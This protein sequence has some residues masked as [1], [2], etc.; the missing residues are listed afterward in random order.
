[1]NAAVSDAFRGSRAIADVVARLA[2]LGN[3]L[4]VHKPECH[5]LTMRRRDLDLLLRYPKA[6][7]QQNV[8]IVDG[9]A[10]WRGLEL[11]PD[12]TPGRYEQRR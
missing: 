12:K 7:A 5:V 1:M 9:V 2:P 3:W 10:W 4:S 8:H 6:A 11:R